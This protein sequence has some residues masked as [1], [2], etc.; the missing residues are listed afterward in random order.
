[1]TNDL[2]NTGVHKEFK[3]PTVAE[4]MKT[5]TVRHEDRY[6]SHV[7]KEI[8]QFLGNNGLKRLLKS[9][10]SLRTELSDSVRNT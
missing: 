9:T 10:K 2:R 8:L 4:G 3:M 5:F 6:H 7:N 1:M